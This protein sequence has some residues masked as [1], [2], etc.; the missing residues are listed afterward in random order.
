MIDAI[1]RLAKNIWHCERMLNNRLSAYTETGIGAADFRSGIK[2]MRAY[3][4]AFPSRQR[5][6]DCEAYEL[7]IG[8]LRSFESNAKARSEASKIFGRHGAKMPIGRGK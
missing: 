4:A 8:Y 1:I 3:Y 6:S 2:K 7:S 5:K